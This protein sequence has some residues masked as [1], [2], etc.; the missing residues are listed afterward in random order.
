MADK[1]PNLP[2]ISVGIQDGNLLPD[3]V[4][5]GPAVVVLGTAT[6]GPSK[7]ESRLVSPTTALARFGLAGTLARGV[8]EA[9]QGGADNAIA[10]RVLATEGR[11]KHIGDVSG[12]AGYTIE[13]VGEGSDVFEKLNI[14]YVNSS[15]LLKVYDVASGAL[16]FSND[17]S[18]PVDLG[19]VTVTGSK[20]TD[21]AFGSIGLQV[22][23]QAD[24]TAQSFTVD[25]DDA[26]VLVMGAGANLALLRPLS[27]TNAYVAQLTTLDG[28]TI[29]EVAV[30]G[31]DAA[32]GV[33]GEVT[34]ASDLSVGGDPGQFAEGMSH[35]IRFVSTTKPIRADKILVNRLFDTDDGES[36]R[37]TPG[38]DFNGLPKIINDGGL[39]VDETLDEVPPAKMNLY[40]ALEDAFN[41]LEASSFSQIVMPGIYLDDPALDGET[42]GATALPD[43][44]YTSAV[45]ADALEDEMTGDPTSGVADR[46]NLRHAS[47]D[48]R[49]AAIAAFEAAGRGACWLVITE[50]KG[51]NFGDDTPADELVRTARIL[52]WEEAWGSTLRLHLDRE[53]SF[54]LDGDGLV[55]GSKEPAF[56]VF[57]T[58]VLFYHR[59]TEVDGELLHQ[60]YHESADADGYTYNE[61]NFGYRLAKFC[62]EMM[63][64]E[65]SVT[66]VIGVRP[67]TNHYNPAAIATWI[68]K[69]PAFDEDGNVSTNGTGLLGNKFISGKLMADSTQFSPGFKA[70]ESGELDD[71]E[72]LL[73]KNNFEVDMGKFL[74]V[75]ASWPVI[76]NEADR[77]GLGYINSGAA[78]YAG[79]VASLPSWRGTTAKAIG[80]RNCKLAAKLAK[81]HQNSLTGSRYVLFDQRPEGVIV[82]DGP[83]F[84]LP[85]SDFTRNMTVR[86]T[87][88]AVQ[89]CRNAARPFLG[90]PLDALKF[91][92][93]QTAILKTLSDLQRISGGALESYTANLTQSQLDKRSGKAKL[94]LTLQII[95]ELRKISVD[96]ALTK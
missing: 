27:P 62:H 87:A 85:T 73:D 33:A 19:V 65:T 50:P 26:N 3:V 17:P 20:A 22:K 42:E 83:S 15:D 60:W 32:A 36:L 89:L 18:A 93:L 6:K 67:P 58:D 54:T 43:V 88:E 31:F 46:F 75:V 71:D 52:N 78:L 64:N 53:L 21:N 56:K 39:T 44:M 94:T 63:E 91:A 70:T 38:S 84:A 34:L 76:S 51:T 68:G 47:S 69:S 86:L 10:Y 13:T 40:E 45:D 81:R 14:L 96:V 72:I 8:I 24:E 48:D 23:V 59:A 66:G 74:S 11:I 16:V 61:V 49:D 57:N 5:A 28:S 29:A 77:T 55:D 25:A 4:P 7:V 2:G 37:I 30:T 92:A 79:K 80:G 12:D 82:V 41:A 1:F 90:D 95:N 35:H 9:F